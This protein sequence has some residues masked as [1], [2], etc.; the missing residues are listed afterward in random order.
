MQIRNWGN[1]FSSVYF[2]SK[3][4]NGTWGTWWKHN[5]FTYIQYSCKGQES[6]WGEQTVWLIFEIK[7]HNFLNVI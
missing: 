1:Q 2:H 4:Y 3:P 5:I 7:K 6:K